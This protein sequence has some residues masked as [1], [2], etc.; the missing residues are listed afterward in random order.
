MCGPRERLSTATSAPSSS[1]TNRDSERSVPESSTSGTSNA[2]I[3][4]TSVATRRSHRRR[5]S[6]PTNATTSVPSNAWKTRAVAREPTP[7]KP[8]TFSAAAS[9]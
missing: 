8:P 4:T 2:A 3:A 1:A 7:S 5:A 6:S 9:A